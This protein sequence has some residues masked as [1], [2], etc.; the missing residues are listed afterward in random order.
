MNEIE[1]RN[2][3]KKRIEVFYTKKPEVNKEREY[4]R[5]ELIMW[6]IRELRQGPV[7]GGTVCEPIS[8]R[9]G[10]S[11]WDAVRT[12]VLMWYDRKCYIC[13]NEATEVHHIRPRQLDG[14]HHPRN[15]I[16]LCTDCHDE[17]H[18]QI[19]EGIR[20]VLTDSVVRTADVIGTKIKN[21]TANMSLD[22]WSK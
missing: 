3:M 5:D 17:I 15:L 19:D 13:G 7:D 9:F 10:T 8:N 20:N 21:K 6:T 11:Y 22:K 14:R 1:I 2:E 12:A 16:P 18:R 4:E